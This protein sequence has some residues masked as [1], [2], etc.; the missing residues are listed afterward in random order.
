MDLFTEIYNFSCSLLVDFLLI[1]NLILVL[2]ER[3]LIECNMLQLVLIKASRS[4][5]LNN[6]SQ[7]KFFCK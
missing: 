6:L 3:F 7:A 1:F 5:N 4:R 2:Y